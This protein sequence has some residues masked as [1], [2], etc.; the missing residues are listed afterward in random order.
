MA[1][2]MKINSNNVSKITQCNNTRKGK[3]CKN[4]WFKSET[5]YNTL[6]ESIIN[7]DVYKS[8]LIIYNIIERGDL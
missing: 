6:K 7:N 3:I 8:N 4:I 5:E 2:N 1:L